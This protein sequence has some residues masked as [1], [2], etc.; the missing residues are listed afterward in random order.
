M[1]G[2]RLM[3]RKPD[4]REA[5]MLPVPSN[6]V[7]RKRIGATGEGRVLDECGAKV[8]VAWPGGWAV[9]RGTLG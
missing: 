8:N 9:A 4:A 6:N 5:G 1:D 2:Q 3:N 7:I